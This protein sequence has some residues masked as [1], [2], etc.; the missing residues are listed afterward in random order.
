ME[1]TVLY[2]KLAM[3][4]Q[5]KFGKFEFETVQNLISLGQQEYLKWAYY[6]MSNIDFLPDVKAAIGIDKD[7]EK[8]G[9]DKEYWEDY[10]KRQHEIFV[11]DE[12]LLRPWEELTE[13]E[14]LEC[15]KRH[16]IKK[17]NKRIKQ[18]RAEAKQRHR[19]FLHDLSPA[20]LQGMNHGHGAG[21]KR[22]LGTKF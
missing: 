1:T 21:R 8:P 6:N 13:E 11:R 22:N 15:Y 4:S 10:K 20:Q 2:R 12:K 14:K 19:E 3:R 9:V 7:I 16:A 17:R 5:L 18:E